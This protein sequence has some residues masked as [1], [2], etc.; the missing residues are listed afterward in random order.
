MPIWKKVKT[1]DQSIA[2]NKWA[3]QQNEGKNNSGWLAVM[4][5]NKRKRITG[6]RKIRTC[7]DNAFENLKRIGSL[8]L[9]INN[10]ENY[11]NKTYFTCHHD[12]NSK[13]QDYFILW[14][15][16]KI[17]N[18]QCFWFNPWDKSINNEL[19]FSLILNL[20]SREKEF[21]SLVSTFLASQLLLRQEN[22]R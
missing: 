17:L 5:R 20:V 15:W 11:W 3:I 22:L 6:K 7:C 13:Y 10:L 14:C 8:S 19:C 21:Y 9:N 18:K 12:A 1:N 4:R 16:Q 2:D